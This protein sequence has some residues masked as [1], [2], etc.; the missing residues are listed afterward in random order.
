MPQANTFLS[1]AFTLIDLAR[2]QL[3]LTASVQRALQNE[4]CYGER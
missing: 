3:Q 1:G 2:P 4:I